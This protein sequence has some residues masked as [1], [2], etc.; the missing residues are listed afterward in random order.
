MTIAT[1]ITPRSGACRQFAA[2]VAEGCA[3]HHGKRHA[4]H[5]SD[6]KCVNAC[7]RWNGTWCEDGQSDKQQAK[8]HKDEG[9]MQDQHQRITQCPITRPA[10]KPNTIEDRSRDQKRSGCKTGGKECLGREANGGQRDR[11]DV[12]LAK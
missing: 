12:E 11:S 10:G 6:G 8:R 1:K 5:R 2:C 9:N 4:G 7:R 3:A